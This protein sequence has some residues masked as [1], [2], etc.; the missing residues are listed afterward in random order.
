MVVR[1]EILIFAFLVAHQLKADVRQYFVGVHVNGS[2]RAALEHIDRELVHAFAVIQD[3]IAG[4][5]NGIGDAFGDSLQL[6]VSLRSGLLHHHHS[7][8][9]FRDI[10]DFVVADVEVFNRS[11]SMDA[12]VSVSWNFPGTQQV[13]FDTNVV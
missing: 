12:V 13:F 6:F 4:G 5:D 7:A 3:L 8:D 9:K 2:A 10:A 1:V 11:Q